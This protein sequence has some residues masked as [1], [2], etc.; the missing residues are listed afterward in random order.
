MSKYTVLILGAKSDVANACIEVFA[1][2]GWDMQLAARNASELISYK[3]LI[4]S[5]YQ[6]KITQHD[7]DIKDID[8]VQNFLDGLPT[9]PDIVV[10]A[11]G[12]LGETPSSQTRPRDVAELIRTNLE[13]PAAI[14]SELANRFE[15]RGSGTLVGISSVAGERGR[16]SNYIYGA[17]KGGFTIFLS[18]LRSRLSKSSVQVITIVPGYIATKMTKNFNLPQSLTVKPE[19]VASS[20]CNAIIKKKNIIYIKPIWKYIMIIIKLIPERIFKKLNL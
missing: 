11:V 7:F 9:L 20:V 16:R 13:G 19:E 12:L 18:G 10:C 17:A 1:K 14:F 3:L 8:G 5:R 2:S 15:K 6:I 4:E